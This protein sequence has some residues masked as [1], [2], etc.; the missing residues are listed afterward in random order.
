MQNDLNQMGIVFK[1][2]QNQN[3]FAFLKSYMLIMLLLSLV[4]SLFMLPS[5]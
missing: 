3:I 2:E 1:I 4:S 5:C